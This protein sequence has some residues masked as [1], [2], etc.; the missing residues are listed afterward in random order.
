[1]KFAVSLQGYVVKHH[2]APSV[3]V[4]ARLASRESAR[5][6]SRKEESRIAGPWEEGTFRA[7]G[8]ARRYLAAPVLQHLD[9]TWSQTGCFLASYR[10]SNLSCRAHEATF[11]QLLPLFERVASELS[12]RSTPLPSSGTTVGS[13]L[14]H[15][16][17]RN[18]RLLQSS[19]RALGSGVSLHF[20]PDSDLE[21][22]ETHS[23]RLLLQLKSCNYLPLFCKIS[24]SLLQLKSCNYLPLNFSVRSQW[25]VIDSSD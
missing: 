21:E 24:S 12:P 15:K 10:S 22:A 23:P 8:Q 11:R 7:G 3:H 18:S 25:F 13:A 17:W 1:M 5:A 20:S 16:S 14:S 9:C 6:Y 4:E 19:L 2:F